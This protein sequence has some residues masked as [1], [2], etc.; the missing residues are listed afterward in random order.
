MSFGKGQGCGSGYGYERS[1][2]CLRTSGENPVVHCVGES[3]E[4]N[5]VWNFS[6]LWSRRIFALARVRFEGL[7][8]C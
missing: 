6:L 2:K 3:G 8:V 5:I 1:R 4:L 7:L